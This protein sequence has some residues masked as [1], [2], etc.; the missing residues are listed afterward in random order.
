MDTFVVVV[1]VVV[2]VV[3]VVAA[4]AAAAAAAV[5]I[6]FFLDAKQAYSPLTECPTNSATLVWRSATELKIH[7]VARSIFQQ[8]A[9]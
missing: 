3:A 8:S 2:V 1:V 7:T 6:L 9:A 5:V 4:A